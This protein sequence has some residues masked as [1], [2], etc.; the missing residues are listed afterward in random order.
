MTHRSEVIKVFYLFRV[1]IIYFFYVIAHMRLSAL[2]FD[3]PACFSKLCDLIA[4]MR[5]D[6]CKFV[7]LLN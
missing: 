3:L 7:P 4:K 5:S 6:K 1:S 2:T